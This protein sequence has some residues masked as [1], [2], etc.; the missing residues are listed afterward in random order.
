MTPGPSNGA[1]L[2]VQRSSNFWL[3]RLDGLF[4]TAHIVIRPANSWLI[5][6]IAEGGFDGVEV[7]CRKVG[8]RSI[9]GLGGLQAD[10]RASHAH[11]Y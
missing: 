6:R 11:H 4:Y 9:R 10:C 2:G 3:T 8:L 1:T 7:V 5:L